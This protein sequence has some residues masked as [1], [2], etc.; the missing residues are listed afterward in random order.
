[1]SSSRSFLLQKGTGV[2]VLKCPASFFPLPG[3]FKSTSGFCQATIT[4][5]EWGIPKISIPLATNF[6]N[7]LLLKHPYPTHLALTYLQLNEHGCFLYISA[8]KVVRK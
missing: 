2:S 5:L 3:K 1:M 7:T 8:Y 4:S 6:R